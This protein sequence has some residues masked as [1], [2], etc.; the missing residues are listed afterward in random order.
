MDKWTFES[1]IAM[2]KR[3]E[4]IE[5]KFEYLYEELVKKKIIDEDKKNERN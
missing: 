4:D 5:A 2:E 3:I 1:L